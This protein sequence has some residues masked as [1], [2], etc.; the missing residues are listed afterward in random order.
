MKKTV[1]VSL[2][3]CNMILDEEAYHV[4]RRF[5][6][7]YS[8]DLSNTENA[9][10]AEEIVEEVEMRMADLLREKLHGHEV[11]DQTMVKDVISEMGFSIPEQ[12][13]RHEPSARR[14]HKLYR[15]K[16]HHVIGGVCSGFANYL[17]V[18]VVIIKIIFVLAAVFGLAGIWIYLACWLIIPAAKTPAEKCEMHGEPVTPEN[19]E[20]YSL[21]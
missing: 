1:S 19:I 21:L 4:L 15:D 10:S 20:K 17:E 7:K 2:G 3:K 5:L 13:V 12:T 11:V 14:P 18:D 6:N 9:S 8:K 16:D